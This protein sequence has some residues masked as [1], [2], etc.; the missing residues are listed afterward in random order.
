MSNA[1]NNSSVAL[2]M[3]VGAALA[4]AGAAR[5][6]SESTSKDPRLPEQ[7][8][9]REIAVDRER[10]RTEDGKRIVADDLVLF[11]AAQDQPLA[12]YT[13]RLATPTEG[14]IARLVDPADETLGATLQ[15]VGPALR[16]QLRIP[17]GQGLLVVSLRGD[18]PSARA[19]L[20]QSDIL[21]SL[22]D[23]PLAAAED[24]TKQLKTVGEKPV[25]LKLL[26]AGKK[27]TLEVRPVYRVTLGPAEEPKAEYY[28]GVAIN[29]ADDALRAQLGLSAHQGV[30]VT[31]V[32]KGS[33]A[34]KAGIEKHDIVLDLAG[35]PTDSPQTLARLVQANG[36]KPIQIKILRAGEPLTIRLTAAARKVETSPQQEALRLWFSPPQSPVQGQ[37]GNVGVLWQKNPSPGSE[38]LWRAV[39]PPASVELEQRLDRL[40]KQ[41]QALHRIDGI[42]KQLKDLHQEL[43]QVRE[44]LKARNATKND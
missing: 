17:A 43:K 38:V 31:D 7:Q 4:L 44:A 32:I 12:L 27:V 24:L 5:A 37:P 9:V 29:P 39:V 14:V 30:V 42:E 41:L 10:A 25:P 15:P 20:K 33:P 22:A 34:E 18:S 23:R 2:A 16:A 1:C 40:D 26:R 8:R 28:L 13:D 19:G 35:K 11:G 36:N 21:L 6:Q 3:V